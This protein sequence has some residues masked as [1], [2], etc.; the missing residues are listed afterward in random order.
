M[1]V[2]NMEKHT[3]Q[4]MSFVYDK[5]RKQVLNQADCLDKIRTSIYAVS[6][7]REGPTEEFL[8]V[9]AQR[10]AKK[11]AAMVQEKRRKSM[12]KRDRTR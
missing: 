1:H 9:K 12:I 11:K 8:L 7:V 6:K 4:H 10:E 2:N 5:T 3:G